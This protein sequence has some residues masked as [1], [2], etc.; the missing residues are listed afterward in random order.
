MVPIWIAVVFISLFSLY[1]VLYAPN[2]EMQLEQLDREANATSVM[3]YRS[4]ILSYL[5]ANPGAVGT[6]PD[7]LLTAGNHWPNGYTAP[8]PTPPDPYVWSNYVDV[9][10]TLYI[11]SFSPDRSGLQK[12]LNESLGDGFIVGEKRPD[13]N[14]WAIGDPIMFAVPAAAGI[15][16]G[17]LVIVGR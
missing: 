10:R 17:A 4:A 2:T 16:D 13:G 12:L 7:A 14:F 5:L 15:P 11:F 9:D 8:L 1:M 3:A 6:I